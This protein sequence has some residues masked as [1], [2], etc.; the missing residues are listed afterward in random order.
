MQ[1]QARAL[2]LVPLL[3]SLVVPACG[4]PTEAPPAKDPSLAAP[5]TPGPTP[6]PAE[7]PRLSAEVTQGVTLLEKND[8]PGA[9]AHFEAALKAD[10]KDAD[11]YYYLGVVAEKAADP[12]SK[13][14]AAEAAYKT[15]LRL[16]P[17]F[18]GAELNLSGLYDDAQRF[19]DALAVAS[20]AIV[21]HPKNASLHLNVAIGFAGKKDAAAAVAE[22]DKALALGQTDATFRLVYGHWLVMLG[23]PD[24]AATQL[25]AA[26]PLAGKDVGIVAAV[27]HELHLAKAFPQCVAAMDKAV[28][29]KDAAELRTERAACKIA[30]K[31]DAGAVADLRAAVASDPNFAPA[32]YYLGNELG[33]AGDFA[34]AVTAYQAF[35]KLEPNGALAKAAAEK[36]RLAKQQ[37]PH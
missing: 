23:Q 34:G 35:I 17:G 21:E 18:E 13:A 36:I 16:R 28:T 24:A 29:L 12:A 8:A 14:G 10:P 32:E 25:Q 31:D 4:S 30:L 11:A 7:G 3:L 22:F 5:E 1:P 9:K 33:K 27:G 2:A 26:L 20:P 37:Q 15:A 19:D 6:P